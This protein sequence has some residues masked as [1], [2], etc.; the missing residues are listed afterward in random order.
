MLPFQE[1][2]E[3]LDHRIVMA[4]AAPVHA[5]HQIVG[6]QKR[7]PLMA[8]ELAALIGMDGDRRFGLVAPDRHQ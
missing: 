2:E 4:V 3:A 7:L 6:L 1:L 8:A 5:G